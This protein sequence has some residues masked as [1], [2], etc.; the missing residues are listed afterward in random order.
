MIEK[1]GDLSFGR[2][3]ARRRYSEDTEITTCC[4]SSIVQDLRCGSSTGAS[5]WFA[6]VLYSPDPPVTSKVS[7]KGQ[8]SRVSRKLV[9]VVFLYTLSQ[10]INCHVLTEEGQGRYSRQ[11]QV[12]QV[13]HTPRSKWILGPRRCSYLQRAKVRKLMMTEAVKQLDDIL[14]VK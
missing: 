6:C 8:E 4:T 2:I 14:A 10:G 7:S 3:R 1:C 12:S 11:D 5:S 13:W 9:M